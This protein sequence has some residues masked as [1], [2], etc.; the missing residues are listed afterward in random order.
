MIYIHGLNSSSKCENA[1]ILKKRYGADCHAPNL[2]N[3]PVLWG[4]YLNSYLS[5]L[6]NTD[7]VLIGS[8]TGGLFANYFANKYGLNVVLI[9]PVVDHKDFVGCI[10][11]N[12][13]Y[14]TSEEWILTKEDVDSLEMYEVD[15]SNVPTYVL[16]GTNDEVLDYRKA[17]SKLTNAKIIKKETDH[18]YRLEE[19]DLKVIDMAR[20][21][22][23]VY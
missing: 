18:R 16:L 2:P 23:C 11:I 9:N 15:K 5:G 6:S 1:I 10:G 13:N 3:N 19:S 20:E 21:V 4:R 7:V 8:S 17:E 22:T 14:H 12:K